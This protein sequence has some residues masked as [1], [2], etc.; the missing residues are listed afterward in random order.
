MK[1]KENQEN[2]ATSRYR[3][4]FDNK[5][6]MCMKQ[7]SPT[8]NPLVHRAVDIRSVLTWTVQVNRT[9]WLRQNNDEKFCNISKKNAFLKQNHFIR[10]DELPYHSSLFYKLNFVSKRQFFINI[11]KYPWKFK[12]WTTKSLKGAYFFL[13]KDDFLYD[14]YFD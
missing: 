6:S 14:M 4:Q 5:N 3:T 9:S 11:G 13:I 7:N 8:P 1:L 12:K 2:D 10:I